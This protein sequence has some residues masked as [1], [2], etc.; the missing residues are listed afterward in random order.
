MGRWGLGCAEES[1]FSSRS[2]GRWGLGGAFWSDH[3][4]DVALSCCARTVWGGVQCSS[5]KTWEE[6]AVDAQ[7]RAVRAPPPPVVVAMAT[8][9]CGWMPGMYRRQKPR[10]FLQ[11]AF[12]GLGLV[13]HPRAAW[14]KSLEREVGCLH[15]DLASSRHE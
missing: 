1:V 6:A 7:A 9:R 4:L 14:S 12:T 13:G 3:A 15:L 5:R 8:E 10:G 2:D 11:W